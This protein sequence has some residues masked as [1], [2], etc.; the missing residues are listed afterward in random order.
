M[1]VDVSQVASFLKEGDAPMLIQHEDVKDPRR[2]N[3]LAFYIA[4]YVRIQSSK[5]GTSFEDAVKEV[6][7]EKSLVVYR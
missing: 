3:S 5:E 4:S 6:R 7:A 1:G 2:R